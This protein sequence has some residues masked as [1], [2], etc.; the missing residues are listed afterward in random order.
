MHRTPAPFDSSS[1]PNNGEHAFG[2]TTTRVVRSCFTLPVS[3][4][5]TASADSSK[6]TAATAPLTN[7][8]LLTGRTDQ[9]SITR[10]N[11]EDS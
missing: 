2:W 1:P 3:L 9:P 5:R 8:L 4:D 11:E 10:N 7:L 6:Q